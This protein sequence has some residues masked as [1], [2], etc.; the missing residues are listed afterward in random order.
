MNMPMQQ[1]QSPNS[2]PDPN[3]D[4][5]IDPN[6]PHQIMNL[7]QENQARIHQNQ[8]MLQMLMQNGNSMSSQITGEL[9]GKQTS[10]TNDQV[11]HILREQQVTIEKLTKELNTKS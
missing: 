9:N 3:I 10:L 7:I 8:M 4:P 2:L 1:G 5:N 6:N 11:V